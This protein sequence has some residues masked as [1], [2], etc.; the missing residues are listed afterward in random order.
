M[1]IFSQS[2]KAT[3]P[4]G[5]SSASAPVPDGWSFAFGA[6]SNFKHR[7]KAQFGGGCTYYDLTIAPGNAI[8]AGN[9]CAADG[10]MS[11]PDFVARI[12]Y[13]ADPPGKDDQHND[14]CSPD[15]LCHNGCLLG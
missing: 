7:A 2:M 6:D 4:N 9:V 1:A 14:Q 13:E 5:L 15:G 10:P 8:G 12:H 11:V 3:A